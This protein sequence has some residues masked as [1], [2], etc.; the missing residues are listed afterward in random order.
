MYLFCK[1]VPYL[2]SATTVAIAA[3]VLSPTAKAASVL[4]QMDDLTET[5]SIY[6]TVGGVQTTILSF[7]E[8]SFGFAL[9]IINS[10]AASPFNVFFNFYEQDGVT[11]SDNLHLFSS[12]DGTNIEFN[13]GND[14]DGGPPLNPL[15]CCNVTNLIETGAYQTVLQFNATNGDNFTVQFRSDV[16]PTPLPAAV[17]LFGSVV[18]GAAGVGKWRK[19]QKNMTVSQ[20]G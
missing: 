12:T 4:Y 3:L 9:P 17:W 14:T 6:R 15:L 13:V 1:R 2:A 11:V 20:V 7:P 16:T 19:R 5:F 8:E 18:A 10:T